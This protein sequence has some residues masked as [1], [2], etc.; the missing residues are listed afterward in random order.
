MG[1]NDA[2]HLVNQLWR[3]VYTSERCLSRTVEFGARVDRKV[4]KRPVPVARAIH[5]LPTLD[6]H[7]VLAGLESGAGGRRQL[8][9]D[10]QV[11]AALATLT[12]GMT[13]RT[14]LCASG[15]LL[16]HRYDCPVTQARYL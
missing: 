1:L 4:S 8:F 15:L 2:L 9:I 7:H 13:A 16:G 3:A 5:W 6:S 10:Q 12:Q 11:L 14:D